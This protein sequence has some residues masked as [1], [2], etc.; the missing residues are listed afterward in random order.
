MRAYLMVRLPGLR[1][2]LR[3]GRWASGLE[4]P[5]RPIREPRHRRLQHR[6]EDR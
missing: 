1:L 5:P 4:H 6:S 3:H 2:L